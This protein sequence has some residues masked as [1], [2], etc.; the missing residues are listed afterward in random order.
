MVNT[1]RAEMTKDVKDPERLHIS[2]DMIIGHD[3][4]MGLCSQTGLVQTLCLFNQLCILH[5]C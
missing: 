5:S 2:I 3:A 1:Y 4:Y